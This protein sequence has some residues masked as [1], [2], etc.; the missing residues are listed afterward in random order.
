MKYNLCLLRCLLRRSDRC[1]HQI[2]SFAII[3]HQMSFDSDTQALFCFTIK[4]HKF[5]LIETS[6]RPTPHNKLHFQQRNCNC[7]RTKALINKNSKIDKNN[8]NST[9][10]ATQLEH[11][12]LIWI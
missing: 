9:P 6:M 5:R 1:D 8:S 4:E 7:T 3:L 2:V 11:I 10:T 12:V